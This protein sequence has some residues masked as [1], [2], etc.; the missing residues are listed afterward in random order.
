MFLRRP[1]FERGIHEKL[2]HEFNPLTT[3]ASIIVSII[4]E[5]ACNIHYKLTQDSFQFKRRVLSFFVII[6]KFES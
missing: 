2:T 4:G 6:T 1:R 3:D 5:A